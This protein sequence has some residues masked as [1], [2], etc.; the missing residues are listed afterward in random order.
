MKKALVIT[1]LFLAA[2]G[3]QEVVPPE[4]STGHSKTGEQSQ[5][6]LVVQDGRLQGTYDVFNSKD[7]L[8]LRYL[9][10]G[11]AKD[12]H[13]DTVW[14]LGST[15]LHITGKYTADEITLDDPKH[16]FGTTKFV[17]GC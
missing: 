2:C 4:C 8:G 16:E 6:K 9:V 7:Q 14:T 5:L 15:A 11:T 1:A 3:N 12:G 17:A 10:D 13:L